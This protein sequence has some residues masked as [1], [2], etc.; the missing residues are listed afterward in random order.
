MSTRA[1]AFLPA[2][3]LA[4]ACSPPVAGS[5][6]G[7]AN[8]AAVTNSTVDTAHPQV[9]QI[10]VS[11]WVQGQAAAVNLY[12][13]GVLV[14]PSTVLTTSSWTPIRIAGSSIY[15]NAY[16]PTN[17]QATVMGEPNSEPNAIGARDMSGLTLLYLD[18]EIAN[19]APATFRQKAPAVGD[20]LSIVGFGVATDNEHMNGPREVGTNTVGTVYDDSFA[21]YGDTLWGN[22]A[23][24]CG[25][26]A[27][28]GVFVTDNGVETLAGVNL[29]S[30]CTA[31]LL[32]PGGDAG[33]ARLDP[34][35]ATTSAWV[36]AN[37]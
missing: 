21:F 30:Q 2:L 31:S 9:V 11:A 24:A 10:F 34:A 15:V 23:L 16:G 25:S 36:L 1:F 5:G 32:H 13:S 26:D 27:G 6:D 22:D 17:T 7:P 8:S 37:M 29:F 20:S 35:G 4:A 18:R 14:G 12:F 3:L 28:G 33:A 19:I